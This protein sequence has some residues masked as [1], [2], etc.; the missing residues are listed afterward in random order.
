MYII[1]TT[2][3]DLNEWLLMLLVI[4]IKEDSYHL[5][6]WILS[7]SAEGEFVSVWYRLTSWPALQNALNKVNTYFI[8]EYIN[9]NY[10]FLPNPTLLYLTYLT[11]SHDDEDDVIDLWQPI[12][13]TVHMSRSVTIWEAS[14]TGIPT[15]IQSSPMLS[16]NLFFCLPFP[17][18]SCL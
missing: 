11:Y 7:S 1:N 17:W 10:L 12:L 18:N 6:E 16:I 13:W 5:W 9:F 8:K 14:C 4:K 15:S 3:N 2:N